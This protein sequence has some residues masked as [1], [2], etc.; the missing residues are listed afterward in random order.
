LEALLATPAKDR[1]KQFTEETDQKL[2][3]KA[4]DLLKAAVTV[5]DLMTALDRRSLRRSRRASWP[6]AP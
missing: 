3:G 1:Q 2:T 6:R 4:V 5:N